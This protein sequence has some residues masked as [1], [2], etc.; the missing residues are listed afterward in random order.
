M[1]YQQS[2]DYILSI[3]LFGK[4]D[5]H[6]NTKELLTKLGNP[7]LS[8][9]Y[10][11]VAG[12]NGKG[13]VCAMLSYI[14]VEAGYEVGFFSSPHL[15]NITERLKIN[16]QDILEDEFLEIFLNIKQGIDE[17]IKEGHHHPT[18]FETLFCMS[19]VYFKKHQVD[20]VI[21]ET[22]LG[23]RLDAT[24][25]IEK[26]LVSVITQ[27]GLDHVAILGNTLEKIAFEKGGIIKEG[28]PTV[29]QS[30]EK[31]V[32][33]VISKLCDEK[34]AP[35]HVVQPVGHNILKST[36]K[37]IDFSLNNKYYKYD[38]LTVNSNGFYQIM[39]A[40]TA[41]T[42]VHILKNEIS[43]EEDSIIKGLYDFYW[44]GRMEVVNEWLMLDGAHNESGIQAFVEYLQ[45]CYKGQ[46]VTLLFTAMKDKAY[47][48]MI[49][50]LS[51][52]HQISKVILTSV[53]EGRCL[54]T[55]T[56]KKIFEKYSTVPIEIEENI[57]KAFFRAYKRDNQLLCCVGSLYLIGQIKKIITGGLVN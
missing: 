37:T 2:V 32:F 3:P 55:E 9:K 51:E 49:K 36:Y 53:Y 14:Y 40:A 35:L 8:L 52:C 56:M 42:T 27:I 17:M 38:R 41:L 25:I 44:P 21:L 19:I 34:N 15:I 10:I 54:D 18:F 4:K 12:T 28:C 24:N 6:N 57:E 43:V 39:N 50:K 31:S 5:G 33:H 16:N 1:N 45:N 29:L 22:G 13:S 7:H 46:Q 47:E 26:P 11:H 48:E 30:D 20:L 23:G